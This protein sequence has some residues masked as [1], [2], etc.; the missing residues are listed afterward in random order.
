MLLTTVAVGACTACT[1]AVSAPSANP[2]L[3]RATTATTTP[4]T[5]VPPAPV[6]V[7][8]P[9]LPAAT[10]LTT[11]P[12]TTVP[13]RPMRL[14]TLTVPLV[15]PSR[16]TISRGQTVSSGRA[17][18]TLVWYPASGGPWPLIVFAHGF[19]VGP[20]PY[21]HLCRA[22]AAAGYVVAAPEFPLTD[23]A[24][25]GAALDENDIQ[26]Q[27]ADVRFVITSLLGPASPLA[28]RI[29]PSRL[30]VAG[31]SDGAETALSVA[32]EG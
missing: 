3:E 9:P 11:L 20:T 7:P 17:L 18:T 19:Q 10:A 13:Q 15:D 6:A 27:P 31:H 14:A 4:T 29:D 25:A 12:P 30:A 28:G 21:E 8:V 16:P 23:G 24:V 22:W 1:P 2:P 5:T 32:T 26:N